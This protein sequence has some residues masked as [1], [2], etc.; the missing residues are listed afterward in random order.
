VREN[1]RRY[2]EANQ[3]KIAERAPRHNALKL[4]RYHAERERVLAERT[5]MPPL[6]CAADGCDQPFPPTKPNKRYCSDRCRDREKARRWRAANAEK[7]RESELRQRPAKRERYRRYRE[8]NP[9]EAREKAREQMRRWRAANPEKAREKANEQMRKW[10]AANLEKARENDRQR[11]A[12]DPEKYRERDRLRYAADP[13]KRRESVRRS[14]A[15]NPHYNR[16]YAKANPH[17][18]VQ[19]AARRRTK[20]TPSDLTAADIKALKDAAHSCPLC[21]VEMTGNST[22]RHLKLATAKELDHIVP[23]AVG[24]LH[25]RA[26]VRVIC[27]GCNLSRPKDGSDGRG[28]GFGV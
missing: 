19:A 7:V 11:R 21:G 18:Y 22:G 9:D 2:R 15:A 3:E 13:K 14:R 4:M 25:V 17:V 20:Y 8:A 5:A 23:L 6:I 16:N 26:N 28:H 24:G 1:A 10:R 27:R 12:A